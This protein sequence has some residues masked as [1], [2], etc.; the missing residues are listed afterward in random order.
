MMDFRRLGQSGLQVSRICLGAMMF[1][2]QT[3]R[4]AVAR[5]VVASAS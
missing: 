1:G 4:L 3:E 5:R 2:D